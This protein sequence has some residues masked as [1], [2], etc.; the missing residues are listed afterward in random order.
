MKEIMMKTLLVL[1][2]IS[3]LFGFIAGPIIVF[4]IGEGIGAG[5]FLGCGLV[6][7]II[8]LAIIFWISFAFKPNEEHGAKKNYEI[9]YFTSTL[10]EDLMSRMN[11]LYGNIIQSKLFPDFFYSFYRK[12]NEVVIIAV[13]Y[14][15]R[16]FCEEQYIEYMNT[17]PEI[18]ADVISHTLI[19]VFI[20]KEKSDYL[21]SIMYAPEYNSL[22][23][24]KVFSVYDEGKKL[25][26]INKTKS[27]T[28]NRAYNDVIKELDKIFLFN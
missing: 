24:T 5:V 3:M 6:L 27:F 7:P 17:I 10:D 11:I 23:D 13:L 22:W 9:K 20:E 16:F 8:F 4:N 15:D 14:T 26:K 2:A 19:V 21:D 12:E 18:M 1:S 25:L 28:G